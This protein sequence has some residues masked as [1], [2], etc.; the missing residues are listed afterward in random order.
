MPNYLDRNHNQLPPLDPMGQRDDPAI[1]NLRSVN[2]MNPPPFSS[3]GAAMPQ[4]PLQQEQ[5]QPLA[6]P[7]VTNP[8]TGR[9]RVAGT[10]REAR[11]VSQVYQGFIWSLR[12]VQQPKRARMCGFGD[13]DRRPITPPPVLLLVITDPKTGRELS[14]DDPQ[15]ED[16]DC[17][18]FIVNVDLWDE[19][20]VSEAILVR[21]S[22]NSP[23]TSIS[24]ATTTAYPPTQDNPHA[25]RPGHMMLVGGD[26][27][28]LPQYGMHGSYG[29]P[30][31]ASYG[32]YIPSTGYGGGIAAPMP[33]YPQHT[34]MPNY[35]RNLIGS[36]SVNAAR[37]KNEQG[38]SGFYFVFQDLS[39]RTEGFF[40]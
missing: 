36:L 4:H 35:T 12:V 18:H 7:Q 24:T 33:F 34:Q 17:S 23:S 39:V 22:S 14:P 16:L 5:Q 9:T 32:Q 37:L 21:S 2:P 27:Y 1:S 15:L 3:A 38:E 10:P 25:Q 26:G 28:N 20:K 13:K 29:M 19:N 40:Q 31:A 6:P 8:V 30:L 11:P